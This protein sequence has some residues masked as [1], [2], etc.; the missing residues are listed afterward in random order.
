[1][2][3]AFEISQFVL[4]RTA[5]SWTMPTEDNPE[6]I[7]PCASCGHGMKLVRITPSSEGSRTVG[8]RHKRAGEQEHIPMSRQNI[9]DVIVVGGASAGVA[10][11]VAAARGGART[12]LVEQAGCL[13]GASTIPNVLSACGLYP[14]G[15]QTRQ[16]VGGVASELLVKL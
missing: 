16:P 10:A 12:P 14:L 7:P 5:Q 8:G 9:F 6:K 13:G 1:M 3:A 2:V 15:A 11:A 4:P